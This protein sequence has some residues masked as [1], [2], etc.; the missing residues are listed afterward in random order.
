MVTR[1]NFSKL[2]NEVIRT[3]SESFK[4]DKVKEIECGLLTVR[5]VSKE[6]GVSQTAVYKWLRLYSSI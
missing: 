1:E 2:A 5:E 3:F 4:R 6:Y